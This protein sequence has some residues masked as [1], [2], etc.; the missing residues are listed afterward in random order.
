M[1]NHELMMLAYD[2]FARLSVKKHRALRLHIIAKTVGAPLFRVTQ[3]KVIKTRLDNR[4]AM[5]NFL[6]DNF[7][8]GHITLKRFALI[9]GSKI[10]DARAEMYSLVPRGEREEHNYL[11][12]VKKKKK[13]FSPSELYE[14]DQITIEEYGDMVYPELKERRIAKS[15]DYPLPEGLINCVVC[16]RDN[17]ADIC[18]LECDHK[19]CKECVYREFTTHADK[20]P[21]L[22]LHSIYCCRNGVPMRGELP[23][24]T[25]FREQRY[26]KLPPQLI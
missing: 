5:N 3:A 16:K 2:K 17:V 13:K 15:S 19:A 7:R 24:I 25:P 22:L 18:C 8:K 11:I 14:S 12:V 21:F 1:D 26:K 10:A 20:R 6:A 23:P 9:M 4:N